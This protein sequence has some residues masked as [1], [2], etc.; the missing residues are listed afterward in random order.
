MKLLSIFIITLA[1]PLC[2]CA[3]PVERKPT[4]ASSSA[5]EWL[6][7]GRVAIENNE[8]RAYQLA[9]ELKQ[10]AKNVILFIGDGMGVSTVTAARILAGQQK[11]MSGEENTLFFEQFPYLAL[12][13]TYNT[14]QQTPD[15]AGTMSAMMTGVKT[16]AGVLSVKPGVTRGDCATQ[17][18][19]ELITVLE[20]AEIAGLSTGVVTTARLTH[21]TPAAT[22]AH[23]IERGFEHDHKARH[24]SNAG[25]CVDIAR[26]LIE[27][28]DRFKHQYP[29]VDGL[30]VAIGGGRRSFLQHRKGADPETGG[31]GKRRD[32]RDLTQEWLKRYPNAAYVWNQAQFDLVDPNKI[33]HLLGLFDRS[34]MEYEVDRATDT[35]G[36]PSLSDMTRKAINILSRNQKGYFLMVESGRID[37]AHHASNP[38]RALTE[39]IELAKAVKVAHKMS[40]RN[41][42]LIIVTADHSHVFTIGGYPTRGNPILGKVINNNAAGES[43]KKLALAEDRK[44]Y[45]TLGY[46]NGP[47]FHALPIGG[48]SVYDEEI[49]VGRANLSAVDTRHRGFHSETGVP[50]AKETHGAEDVVIYATGAGAY[51]VN[52]VLE[53]NALFQ[54]IIRSA[55][56]QQQ[57]EAKGWSRSAADW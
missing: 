28:P 29:W 53:Q 35:G 6:Q 54:V 34:H 21:A 7:Q 23:S 38:Y 45:T 27:F 44:P 1:L 32:G 9:S 46:T 22:Y 2:A 41:D 4:I 52:G 10:K 17:K 26:Q 11:G 5:K 25:D 16:K 33:Q 19:N 56:L 51:R 55:Q 14:N 3:N 42:T 48:D 40:Q 36:E 47:G 37:H 8:R 43:R 24:L 57:A 31:K 50:L 20:L 12:S 15:S 18:G 49:N 30:E 13:K 39:T